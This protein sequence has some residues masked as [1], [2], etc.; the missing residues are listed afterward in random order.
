MSK[1]FMLIASNYCYIANYI[2]MLGSVLVL[3]KFA[4]QAFIG[5]TITMKFISRPHL[6]LL[7]HD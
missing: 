4:E 3:K 7:P 1:I 6:I 5:Q 2:I